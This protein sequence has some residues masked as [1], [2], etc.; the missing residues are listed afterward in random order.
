MGDLRLPELLALP[1]ESRASALLTAG[2]VR[3]R[4][5]NRDHGHPLYGRE[6]YVFARAAGR[7]RVH[8]EGVVFEDGTWCCAP[9]GNWR[10]AT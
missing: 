6:G 4:Y 1:A 5:V 2:A 7:S 10:R 3:V 9:Y 8:N